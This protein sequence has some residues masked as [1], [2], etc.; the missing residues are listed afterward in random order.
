MRNPRFFRTYSFS[1]AAS[2]ALTPQTCKR[3]GQYYQSIKSYPYL[4]GT[5]LQ[6]Q[7]QRYPS[8]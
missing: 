2:V 6:L 7:H 5:P 3:I 8:K 1:S 4:L